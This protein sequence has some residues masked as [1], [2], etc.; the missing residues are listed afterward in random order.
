MSINSSI[1]S[2]GLR[3][4]KSLDE[5]VDL[6]MRNIVSIFRGITQ[7]IER[8][9]S[10]KL[11]KIASGWLDS[12]IYRERYQHTDQNLRWSIS[13]AVVSECTWCIYSLSCGWM[14][15]FNLQ[16]YL[17]PPSDYYYGSVQEFK[18]E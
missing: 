3:N 9:M 6:D 1:E 8:C 5:C 12:W 16:A 4:S 2:L 10:E 13:S 14:D 17:N 11:N 18:S 7:G 15:H